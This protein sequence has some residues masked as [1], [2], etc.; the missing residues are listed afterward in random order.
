VYLC[1]TMML[2]P[3]TALMSFII[4]DVAL[5]ARCLLLHQL[6]SF[7][8]AEVDPAALTVAP[9]K[10]RL[11]VTSSA[12]FTTTGPRASSPSPGRPAGRPRR[13]GSTGKLE[14]QWQ[15]LDSC[16]CSSR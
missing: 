13:A 16:C 12:T 10:R 3:S 5:A 14:Q 15:C 11:Q 2:C 1:Q 9:E 6:G 8:D 4:T 7:D